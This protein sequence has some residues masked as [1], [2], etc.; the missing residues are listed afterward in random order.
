MITQDSILFNAHSCRFF[1]NHYCFVVLSQGFFRTG[2][3]N[4]CCPMDRYLTDVA[5][6]RRVGSIVFSYNPLEK[7]GPSQDE[8]RR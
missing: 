1:D 6:L 2:K 8:K 5:Y 3:Q 7:I 4:A